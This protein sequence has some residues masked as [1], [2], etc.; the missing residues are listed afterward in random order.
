MNRLDY[1]KEA[2]LQ[3][4]ETHRG[5]LRAEVGELRIFTPMGALSAFA[6][7]T[8]TRL[9]LAAPLLGL[10][11]RD[12]RWSTWL[13]VASAVALAGLVV[14]ALARRAQHAVLEDAQE[15]GESA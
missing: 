11:A 2:I 3:R 13:R 9:G 6:R 10:F 14:T 15:P 1:E 5:Q 7:S 12:S 4:I 8:K